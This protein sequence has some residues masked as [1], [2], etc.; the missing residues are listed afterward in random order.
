MAI[1][2]IYISLLE[3]GSPV[4]RPTTAEDLGNGTFKVMPTDNYNPESEIWEFLPGSNVRC[5]KTLSAFGNEMLLAYEE[6]K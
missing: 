2:T 5:K 3:E 6:V 4:A 1:T